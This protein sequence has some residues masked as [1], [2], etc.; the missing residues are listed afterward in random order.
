MQLFRHAGRALASAKSWSWSR[1]RS[2]GWGWARLSGWLGATLAYLTLGLLLWL[3]LLTRLRTHIPLGELSDP[4]VPFFNLWTL[5]WNAQRLGHGFADYWNAPIFYPARDTFAL[6]EPQGVTGLIFTPLQAL[7]G[8]VAGYNLTLLALLIGNGLA[9]RRL[10]VASGASP[11][12]ATW[13]GL[14]FVALPLVREELGVLQLCAAW[15]SLLGFAEIALLTR[16]LNPWAV[17]RLGLWIVATAWSCIYYVLFFAWLVALAGPFVLR[18]G[19]LDRRLWIA[20]LVA[21][22]L[23]GAGIRPLLAAERR[24]VSQHT[25]SASS[26]H[27]GSGSALAYLHFPKDTPLA[28]LLPR[29]T[30]PPG[31]RSLYPGALVCMLALAGAYASRRRRQRWL[32]YSAAALLLALLLSFGTR[33]H[34]GGYT[35]YEH[36]AQRYLPGFDRLRS[37][38]RAALFVQLLLTAWAGLGLEAIA[39]ALSRR[40]RPRAARLLPAACVLVALFEVTPWHFAL[41]RFPREALSEPWI[42]WLAQQP[43][44]PVAMLPP[45]A[46][47][48]AADYSETTVYMLQALRHGHPIVNGYSGF[49]PPASDRMVRALRTFPSARSLRALHESH[50]RYAVVARRLDAVR[51]LE[52]HPSSGL[53]LVYDR[54]PRLVFLVRGEGR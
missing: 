10:L 53:T 54:G 9:G 17:V 11:R 13:A 52:Q 49:F 43:A 38:Y 33:L 1:S 36:T 8:P 18:R 37:P 47:G 24:A 22:G 21:L 46:T 15:P 30:R 4:T 5:S 48:H 7:A 25:R 27:M 40:S 16:R 28:R 3:P 34:L 42:A 41:E 23:M 31:R 35:P 39:R 44:G 14:L 50:I 2:W 29:W 19:W 32:A 20:A 6:S 26:I 12:H 45:N 51:K